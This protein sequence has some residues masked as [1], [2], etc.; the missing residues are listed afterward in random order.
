M[1]CTPSTALGTVPRVPLFFSAAEVPSFAGLAEATWARWRWTL[2]SSG[3]CG[4][5]PAGNEPV[6]GCGVACSRKVLDDGWLLRVSWCF[7]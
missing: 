3:R 7:F 1:T 6:V 2:K 5:G 4:G